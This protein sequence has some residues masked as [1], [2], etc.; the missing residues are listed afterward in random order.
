MTA[1][2]LRRT[3]EVNVFGA[4]AVT[5]ACLPLPRRSVAPRIVNMSSPLGS[6][7]MLSDPASQAAAHA[8]LGY[9]SSKAA[10][11]VT[12]DGV[13]LLGD[14][15]PDEWA[16]L[17]P[18]VT[19]ALDDIVDQIHASVVSVEVQPGVVVAHSLWRP[20]R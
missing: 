8:L 19:P 1:D 4:V 9:S 13:T 18:A 11:N 2:Q 3:Y 10:L 17:E 7:H 5:R 15:M 14:L 16:G 12:D 6:M 20:S